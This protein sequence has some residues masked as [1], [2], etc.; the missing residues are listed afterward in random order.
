MVTE[1][2]GV[3]GSVM[4]TGREINVVTFLPFPHL[5]LLFPSNG[6]LLFGWV[7]YE[8]FLFSGLK[9]WLLGT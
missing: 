9:I 5:G 4:D 6:F 3:L 7:Q 2:I 8:C 1:T